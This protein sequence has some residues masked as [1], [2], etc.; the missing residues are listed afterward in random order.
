MTRVAVL[1]DERDRP[2]GRT[3]VVDQTFCIQ[4]DEAFYFRTQ[5]MVRL[6]G[7][8]LGAKFILIE[9]AVRRKLDPV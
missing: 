7:G 8:G 1:Y 4:Y 5:H 9:P 2:I 3:T 6:A